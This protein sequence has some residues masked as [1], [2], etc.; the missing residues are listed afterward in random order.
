MIIPAAGQGTRLGSPLPKALVELG[1][2]SLIERT[3]QRFADLRLLR[4][5]IVLAPPE[6]RALFEDRLSQCPDFKA[7][8]II[9]GGVERQDSVRKGLDA[10]NPATEIVVIHDAARPFVPLSAIRESIKAARTCGAATVAI[11][12]IDTILE[13]DAAGF[14]VQTPDRKRLWACQTPQAFRVEVIRQAHAEARQEGF[15]G[16]DDATLVRRLGGKVKIVPGA[17]EN[18]KV[19]TPADLLRAQQM[20][21]EEQP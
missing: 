16:T 5:L 3:L 7:I 8:Q 17:P 4:D 1:G 10:L 9:D 14:L 21:E 15:L 13:V 6:Q 12:S 18:F 19:T 2:R 11:P 20:L